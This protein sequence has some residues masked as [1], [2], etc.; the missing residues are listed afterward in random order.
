MRFN[1]T[2]I[3]YEITF[4]NITISVA[5]WPHTARELISFND[6][7]DDNFISIN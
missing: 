7:D 4:M 6:L 3:N 2:Y 1:V 5:L